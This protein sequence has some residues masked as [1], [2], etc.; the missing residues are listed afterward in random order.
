MDILEKTF[1]KKNIFSLQRE[2][3]R[4]NLKDGDKKYYLHNIRI[5]KK[6][7]HLTNYLK[8]GYLNF[9]I[10]MIHY[11]YKKPLNNNI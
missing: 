10:F 9:D 7:Y 8:K 1:S 4:K 11:K 5:C 3:I 6:N 2:K